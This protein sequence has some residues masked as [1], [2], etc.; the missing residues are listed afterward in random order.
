MHPSDVEQNV[1]LL[2]LFHPASFSF[3][4]A[5]FL[6]TLQS[7]L[8]VCKHVNLLGNQIKG[9]ERENVEDATLF[10]Q[11]AWPGRH[12]YL[13]HLLCNGQSQSQDYM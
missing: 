2:S 1:Q 3:L 11:M 10:L 5:L 6:S 7:K 4:Q 12:T 13:F 8:P 9:Q